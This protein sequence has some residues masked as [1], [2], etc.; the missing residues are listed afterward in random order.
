MCLDAVDFGVTVVVEILQL[1]HQ[2]VRGVV[3]YVLHALGEVSLAVDYLGLV[4]V[5]RGN[6]DGRFRGNVRGVRGVHVIA[7]R[8]GNRRVD[9]VRDIGALHLHRGAVEHDIFV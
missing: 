2:V 6:D 9:G 1:V 4:K 7:H 8:S 5:V 3:G